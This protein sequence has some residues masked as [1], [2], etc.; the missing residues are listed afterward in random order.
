M[1]HFDANLIEY[2]AALFLRITY[3]KGAIDYRLM[4][5]HRWKVWDLFKK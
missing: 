1:V 2:K 5:L 3:E 4:V